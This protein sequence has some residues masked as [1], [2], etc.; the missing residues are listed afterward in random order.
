VQRAAA[1]PA[2]GEWETIA[3]A[4][5]NAATTLDEEDGAENDVQRTLRGIFAHV[6]GVRRLTVHDS[7]FDMGGDSLIAAQL[8]AL[9]RE[10]FPVEISAR[11]VFEAPTVA[12]LA[13]LIEARLGNQQEEVHTVAEHNG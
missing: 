5:S 7:F 1:T 13:T 8:V 4:S 3:P 11:V 2:T 12:E 6:L 9:V 10:A